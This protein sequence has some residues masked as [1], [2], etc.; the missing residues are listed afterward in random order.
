MKMN[1]RWLLGLSLALTAVLSGCGE[2]EAVPPP[3]SVAGAVPLETSAV[4]P[5]PSE[6]PGPTAARST[7][8]TSSSN[9]DAIQERLPSFWDDL[10]DR[11]D[12]AVMSSGVGE[13][14]I[15]MTVRSYG[16]IERKIPDGE[17]KAIKEAIFEYFGEEFALKLGQSECC[18][19]EGMTGE[20]KEIDPAGKR[21]LVVSKTKKNG[22]TED[23]EANWVTMTD[24][25]WILREGKK[26]DFNT[27]AV[28]H[29][30]AYWSTGLFMT[31]YPGQTSALKLVLLK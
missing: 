28:G 17:M 16:D 31:S 27:L 14:S 15:G 8:S 29:E 13:D 2:R 23:P 22:N 3:S 19:G 7:H 12:I 9:L 21:V 24:D 6:S 25:G 4:S 20:I 10:A 11:F 1:I 5:E 30:V 26:V 18:A